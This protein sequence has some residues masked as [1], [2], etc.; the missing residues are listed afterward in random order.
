MSGD[1]EI[2]DGDLVAKKAFE[3]INTFYSKEE[4]SRSVPERFQ[5][6]GYTPNR[7]LATEAANGNT[8]L[9]IS[10]YKDVDSSKFFIGIIG[11]S[12]PRGNIEIECFLAEVPTDG[13]VE[14]QYEEHG[15][16]DRRTLDKKTVVSDDKDTLDVISEAVTYIESMRDNLGS[17]NVKEL[18]LET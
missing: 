12:T 7:L 15:R 10:C 5:S 18:L 8:K 4:W 3:L 2:R 9:N 11:R 17:K 14:M 16:P 6:D 13:V 1:V